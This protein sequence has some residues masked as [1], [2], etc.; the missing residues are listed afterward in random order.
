[1]RF[2]S[3]T[4]RNLIEDESN[5]LVLDAGLEDLCGKGSDESEKEENAI[6]AWKALKDADG[7]IIDYKFLISHSGMPTQKTCHLLASTMCYGA[8][9]ASQA[10]AVIV[11][12]TSPCDTATCPQF[13]YW[14]C[15]KDLRRIANGLVLNELSVIRMVLIQMKQLASLKINRKKEAQLL[16]VGP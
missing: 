13:L 5:G 7:V 16:G 1:M 14:L 15:D 3:R 2:G 9:R 11:S 10:I 4:L 12:E 6:K 8:G